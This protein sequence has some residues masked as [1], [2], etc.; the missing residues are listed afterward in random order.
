MNERFDTFVFLENCDFKNNNYVC[1]HFW[2]G[3]YVAMAIYWDGR[4]CKKSK[5]NSYILLINLEWIIST[6]NCSSMK[7]SMPEAHYKKL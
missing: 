7:K 6:N 5:Q 1:F 4:D 2:Q 3:M